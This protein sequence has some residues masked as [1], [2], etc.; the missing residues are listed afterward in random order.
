MPVGCHVLLED[1][2]DATPIAG[3]G[4]E[5]RLFT[6]CRNES[7]RLPA[8]LRHY[9][10]LGVLRFFFVDNASTD[11]SLQFLKAQPD[12]RVFSTSGSF[13]EARGGTDWLNALLGK[14]GV[15]HWCVTVDVDELLYYPGSE[16]AGLPTLCRYLDEQGH[17]ALYAMLLDLYPGTPLRDLK[18]APGDDLESA[19]PYFDPG[20]YR[21]TPHHQCPGFLV[22]GGV[23]ERVFYPEARAGD[24]RRDLHVT[25]YH[26]ILPRVPLVRTLPRV[27]AHRPLFPP[28]LT[29]IPL[30]RWEADTRYLNVN[31]FVS[32]RKVAPETGVLLHFKLLQDFHARVETEV[33]RAEYYDGAVEFRR[34][35]E[36]LEADPHLSFKYEGSQRFEDSAQLVRL[37]LMT[38]SAGWARQRMVTQQEPMRAQ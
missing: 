17:Q 30:V 11:G 28:C 26:R 13:R 35:A 10:A 19:A 22:Y 25:L 23:R 29:K 18:Y 38:D 3:R 8:F 9:R 37:G 15:G 5:I 21:R 1:E 4:S 34:Y 6:K 31:H 36:R 27:H 12:V 14:Y 20:P 2:D 24:L 32:P 16:R 33:A 7:L